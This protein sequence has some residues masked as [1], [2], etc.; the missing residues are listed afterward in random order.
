M[1]KRI[2]GPHDELVLPIQRA[3]QEIKASLQDVLDHL[4]RLTQQVNPHYS[5]GFSL[6]ARCKAEG[7]D[8][9]AELRRTAD[10]LANWRKV[11]QALSEE[12]YYELNS[13]NEKARRER[14]KDKRRK[15]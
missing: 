14:M 3:D 13:A 1:A 5:I 15:G 2:P 10:A 7:Y 11:S 8:L 12:R 6:M 4:R 9:E